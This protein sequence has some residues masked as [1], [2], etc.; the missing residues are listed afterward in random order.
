V[1]DRGLFVGDRGHHLKDGIELLHGG[2]LA[3]AV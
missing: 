2:F 1:I 3:H